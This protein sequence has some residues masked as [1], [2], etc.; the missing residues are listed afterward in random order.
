MSKEAKCVM[1]FLGLLCLATVI[2]GITGCKQEGVQG[3]IFHDDKLIAKTVCEEELFFSIK[4][5]TINIRSTYSSYGAWWD[6]EKYVYLNDG[7]YRIERKTCLLK[8][9]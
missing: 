8:E 6:K 1:Y 7:K 9:K 3:F 5:D 4:P 2:F